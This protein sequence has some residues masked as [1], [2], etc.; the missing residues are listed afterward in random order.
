MEG[1]SYNLVIGTGNCRGL[2]KHE[3]KIY[4]FNY[5]KTSEANLICLQETHWLSSEL[6][7]IKRT[8]NNPYYIHGTKTNSRGVAIL[9]KLNFEY[10]VSNIQKDTDVNLSQ[11]I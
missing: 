2:C 10:E 4:V 11:W 9:F 6:R 8:W 3:N 7:D 5:L 1:P